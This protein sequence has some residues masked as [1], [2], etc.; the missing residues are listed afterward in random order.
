MPNLPKSLAAVAA[1][2]DWYDVP[3]GVDEVMVAVNGTW[4]GATAAVQFKDAAGTAVAY[5]DDATFTD[6]GAI[7]CAAWR[8]RQ[9][10]VAITVATP[11]LAITFTWKG[12]R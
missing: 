2:T 1:T 12:K 3:Q 5:G 7:I 4:N 10:R 9:I 6:D 8:A 11:A